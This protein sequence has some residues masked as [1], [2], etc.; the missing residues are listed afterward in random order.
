MTT[1]PSTEAR[2]RWR[3][4]ARLLAPDLDPGAFSLGEEFYRVAYTLRRI[5]ESS[6][7][8]AGLSHPQ[9]RILLSLL[10]AELFGADDTLNPSEISG[11]LGVSR[12]AVSALL[13]SLE[14]DGLIERRLDPDD[15]RRFDLSLSDA[16]RELA[17][18]HA[19]HHLAAIGSCFSALDESEQRELGRLLR[20]LGDTGLGEAC[21]PGTAAH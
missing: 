6:L 2:R 17:R 7:A 5:G 1:P 10:R 18:R 15:R 13:R 14:Q 12:N 19:R 16:G 11:A 21:D 4:L 9:F 20:K 3:E 8:D